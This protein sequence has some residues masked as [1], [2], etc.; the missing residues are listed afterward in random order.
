[1]CGVT[2]AAESNQKIVILLT[3]LS[4][5]APS[6]EVDLS[7]RWVLKLKS[8]ACAPACIVEFELLACAHS[9]VP[10]KLGHLRVGLPGERLPKV[11]S[12]G[13]RVLAHGRRDPHEKQVIRLLQLNGKGEA[14]VAVDRHSAALG[15]RTQR[16]RYKPV[17]KAPV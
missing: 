17:A 6:T 4:S 14:P 12:F 1:V 15:Q 10:F 9:L 2:K 13:A 7:L 16:H 3:C 5:D 11:T 8:D